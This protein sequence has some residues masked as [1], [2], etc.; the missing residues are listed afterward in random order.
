MALNLYANRLVGE[1]PI[2]IWALDDEINFVSQADET[3]RDL[4]A[5]TGSNAT[6]ALLGYEPTAPFPNS[7]T[8]SVVPTDFAAT[9]QLSLTGPDLSLVRSGEKMHA[10]FYIHIN[11]SSIEYIDFGSTDGLGAYSLQ[12]NYMPPTAA[13][14]WGLVTCNDMV[15][16]IPHI[17]IKYKEGVEIESRVTYLINGFVVGENSEAHSSASLGNSLVD[18]DSETNI[19]TQN[20]SLPAGVKG[21]VKKSVGIKEFDTVYFAENNVL[22]SENFGLP[23]AYGSNNLLSLRRGTGAL[24]SIAFDGNGFLTETGRH[25]SFTFEMWLRIDGLPD[26]PKRIFGPMGNKPDTDPS[27]DGL[28]LNNGVITLVVGNRAFISHN[29]GVMSSP[30]LLHII[31]SPT[32][33]SLMINGEMVRSVRIEADSLVFA[34]AENRWLGMWVSEEMHSFDVDCFS[35]FGYPIT[36][37]A[38]KRRFVWG[39]GVE[40]ISVLNSVYGGKEVFSTT[41]TSG[42]SGTVSYPNNFSWSGGAFDNLSVDNN[43]LQPPSTR[44]PEISLGGQTREEWLSAIEV[45]NDGSDPLPYFLMSPADPPAANSPKEGDFGYSAIATP[46]RGALAQEPSTQRY[47]EFSRLGDYVQNAAGLVVTWSYEEILDSLITWSA[48]P[49]DGG[50]WDDGDTGLTWGESLFVPD[51]PIFSVTSPSFQG[52]RIFA[53]LHNGSKIRMLF[54]DGYSET[55]LH[56]SNFDSTKTYSTFL[57]FAST[58][59]V[60]NAMKG[61]LANTNDLKIVLFSDGTETFLGKIYGVGIVGRQAF[62][63]SVL[64]LVNQTEAFHSIERTPGDDYWAF[65]LTSYSWMPK[66]DFGFTYED[67]G[68]RGYWQDYIPLSK[69]GVTV[70]NAVGKDVLAVDTIQFN[71]GFESPSGATVSVDP[72]QFTYD[73]LTVELLNEITTLGEFSEGTYDSWQTD[74]DTYRESN[75][76][77]RCSVAFQRASSRKTQQSELTLVRSNTSAIFVQEYPDYAE[78]RFALTSGDV[79]VPPQNIR[80][81]RV[82]MTVFVEFSI[83]GIKTYPVKLRKMEFLSFAKNKDSFSKVGSSSGK[84]LFPTASGGSFYDYQSPNPF[85]VSDTSLPYLYLGKNTGYSSRAKRYNNWELGL[86]IPVHEAKSSGYKFDNIQFWCRRNGLFSDVEE[87]VF[88]FRYGAKEILLRVKAYSS[89]GKRGVINCYDE[90]GNPDSTVVFFQDGN[91]VGRPVIN[92]S[93]W[94][95][96]QIVFPGG[97]ETGNSTPI[98]K[99][100][101]GLVFNNVSYFPIAPVSGALTVLYRDWLSVRE[102]DAIPYAWQDWKVVDGDVQGWTHVLVL[103]TS[104]DQS[105]AISGRVSKSYVGTNRIAAGV[106]QPFWVNQGRIV[107]YSD[108]LWDTTTV[109]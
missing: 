18:L 53:Y 72:F 20:P 4:T 10:S 76:F 77:I 68:I 27:K 34:K 52:C 90:K 64:P 26:V 6:V 11:H 47:V 83:P 14:T 70:K 43:R 102:L 56:E 87:D 81:D 85:S 44:L 71:A 103:G 49:N 12:R 75:S 24:P 55:L 54:S 15:Y 84:E 23:M 74:T 5:W 95:D 73:E 29:V 31:Y 36:E 28:W 2:S 19:R 60:P 69:L 104:N 9:F 8:C 67:I 105:A 92:V 100:M 63:N 107:V 41:A 39:Q 96:I 35:M 16:D 86:E 33:L 80:A 61:M 7:S 3:D 89:D 109:F 42:L 93:G 62:T 106:G 50:P 48:F 78:K 94:S 99:L 17:V 98:I 46:A 91:L 38:A 79:L 45:G 22:L 30:I 37:L 21:V 1:Y 88:V 51:Q 58:Q 65:D 13:N 32:T 108:V 25:D 97:L 101:R 66:R 82:M 40:N 59:S 57:N